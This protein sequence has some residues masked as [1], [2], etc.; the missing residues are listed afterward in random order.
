VLGRLAPLKV[1]RDP[2]IC[3][4]CEGCTR[5]CPARLTVHTKIRVSSVE[6]SGCQDCVVACPEEG[7]LTVRPPL[8][9][10]SRAWLR[11][12]TPIAIALGIYLAV[13]VGF[14]AAGHWHTSVTEA[15]YHERLQELR[16]P[17]Y[18]HPR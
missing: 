15:E 5:V 2:E 18:T 11:P 8:V 7:C 14:R 13:V 17:K 10:R 9:K 6:C 4:S 16:D 1:T 3:T 12:A